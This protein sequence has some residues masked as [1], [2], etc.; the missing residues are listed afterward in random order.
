MRDNDSDFVDIDEMMCLRKSSIVVDNGM[1]MVMKK[2]QDKRIKKGGRSIVDDDIENMDNNSQNDSFEEESFDFSA[3]EGMFQ[4]NSARDFDGFA[5]SLDDN[6]N[7][8]GSAVDFNEH[9]HL[10]SHCD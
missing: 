10:Y 5:H 2:V 3:A 6:F 1:D 9:E 7:G 8:L 4:I